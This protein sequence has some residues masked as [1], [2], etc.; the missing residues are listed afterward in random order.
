MK[1]KHAVVILS[2][3]VVWILVFAGAYAWHHRYWKI[4]HGYTPIDFTQTG[5]ATAGPGER[6]HMV[7]SLLATHDFEG[8]P[9]SEVRQLLGTPDR[10]YEDHFSY[11]VGYMG[12]NPRAPM[13][14]SYEL[15]F[16]LDQN[17]AVK[18]VFTDD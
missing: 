2:L 16:E 3:L 4:Y 15:H 13:V 12:F 5:W 7:K 10:S 11:D 8:K 6:G 17:G 14:F 18:A 1:K 9:G